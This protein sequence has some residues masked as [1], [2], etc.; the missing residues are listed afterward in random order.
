M[1]SSTPLSEYAIV[2][3]SASS[4]TPTT[5][6]RSHARTEC[7]ALAAPAGGESSISVSM[8]GYFFSP[9]AGDLPPGPWNFSNR[10]PHQ[11]QL[12]A[13]SPTPNPATGSNVAASDAQPTCPKS[14]DRVVASK[15]HLP[16]RTG[17]PVMNTVVNEPVDRRAVRC[18]GSSV[19]LPA[20]TWSR[21]PA[22]SRRRIAAPVS[23]VAAASSSTGVVIRND[24]TRSDEPPSTSR[25]GSASGAR[26]DTISPSARGDNAC[27]SSYASY[28]VGR[29]TV[30][31]CFPAD[32][33]SLLPPPSAL[34]CAALTFAS[35]GFSPSVVKVLS[36]SSTAMVAANSSKRPPACTLLIST[37][38]AVT[39]A[40]R[41]EGG[42]VPG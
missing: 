24:V 39:N 36:T 12:T 23:R 20:L 18:T 1:P 19:Q 17:A 26:N 27:V 25:S 37:L 28:S 35:T 32:P 41:A 15:Y 22:C 3:R 2:C 33:F 11:D 34:R 6:P 21:R 4:K 5:S 10:A 40:S 16:L 14:D 8:Q 7:S 30:R 13:S 38:T 29:S 31:R 9:I 42:G